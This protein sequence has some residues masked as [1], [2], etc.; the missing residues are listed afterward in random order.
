MRPKSGGMRPWK[1]TTDIG[2]GGGGNMRIE[3]RNQHV[4]VERLQLP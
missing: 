1:Q 4:T 3:G 2:V